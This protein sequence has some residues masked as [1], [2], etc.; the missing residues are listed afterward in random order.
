MF[1]QACIVQKYDSE[2]NSRGTAPILAKTVATAQDVW[3][4][5]VRG[6]RDAG[7]D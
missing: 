4:K 2:E 7:I 1:S 3:G 5:S 6:L